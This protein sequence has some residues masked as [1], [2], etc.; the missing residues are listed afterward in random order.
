MVNEERVKLMTRL[1]IYE[2]TKG[3]KQLNISKYYKHDYVRFH[4]MKSAVTA[5]LAYFMILGIYGLY[6]ANGGIFVS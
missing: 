3:K 5:T 2:T 1:A 6:Q 4:M